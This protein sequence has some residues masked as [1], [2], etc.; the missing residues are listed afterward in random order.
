MFEKSILL[1]AFVLIFSYLT[2]PGAAHGDIFRYVDADGVV[3]FTNR[4][5]S[6]NYEFFRKES[7]AGLDEI[8]SHYAGTYNLEEPL[9]RAVIK[10]ESNYNPTLVSNKG[11][12]GLMQLM[13]ETARYLRLN[14]GNLTDPEEN[15]RGGTRYLRMMLDQFGGDLEL[16]LAAYN[17]GP[18]TVRQYGGIPPYPETQTYVARVKRYLASYR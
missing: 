1:T 7:S 10:A 11:A 3:H 15:I 17:A 12:V 4:P 14:V 8:I 5:T 18:T 2:N 16:A 9:V 6:D 13:P